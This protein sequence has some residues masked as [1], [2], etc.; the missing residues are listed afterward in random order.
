MLLPS[1]PFV[2]MLVGAASVTATAAFGLSNRRPSHVP[3]AVV[4]AAATPERADCDAFNRAIIDATARLRSR[5]EVMRLLS[6]QKDCEPVTR[7]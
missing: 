5:A 4:A 6:L 7:R 3:S 1:M 2:A